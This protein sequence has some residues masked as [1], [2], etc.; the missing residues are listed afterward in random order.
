MTWQFPPAFSTGEQR[1]GCAFI[2]TVSQ[3][4]SWIIKNEFKHLLQLFAHPENLEWFSI[5][6][7]STLLLNRNN[8]ID[9]NFFYKF[10]LP[11]TFLLP[12]PLPHHCSGF[13]TCLP[14]R[15]PVCLKF[16]GKLPHNISRLAP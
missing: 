7:R 16:T 9:N 3:V 15:L 11:S 14:K 2:T 5:T 10:P 8:H 12:P 1:G 6:L 4:N 13:Q